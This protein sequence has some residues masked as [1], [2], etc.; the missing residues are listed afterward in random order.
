MS[1]KKP[2]KMV[3]GSTTASDFISS[4]GYR[5][6]ISRSM[7]NLIGDDD[8]DS[9]SSKEEGYQ[10][11]DSRDL[12]DMDEEEGISNEHKARP[13]IARKRVKQ[14]VN[15][16]E[17]ET[18]IIPLSLGH[19]IDH[20]LDP[21]IDD[22]P[23]APLQRM[24][25]FPETLF[26]ILCN[27]SLSDIIT[28]RPHGRS[29]TILDRSV[30][31]RSVLPTYY[32]TS[33]MGSF[34]KQL[35]GY[36]FNK[37]KLDVN[38]YTYYHPFFLRG[39]PHLVKNI[40]RNVSGTSPAKGGKEQ[41]TEADLERISAEAPV[42]DRVSETSRANAAIQRINHQYEINQLQEE[43]S[44][45]LLRAQA[46]VSA[47]FPSPQHTTLSNIFAGG[48][49][50]SPQV[51]Y[52]PMLPMSAT[53]QFQNVAPIVNSSY[54]HPGAYNHPQV[55]SGLPAPEIPPP[56]GWDT[57]TNALLQAFQTAQAQRQLQD[58]AQQAQLTLLA[59]ALAADLQNTHSHLS[60]P[61]L[62]PSQLGALH[63]AV[64]NLNYAHVPSTIYAP[65]WV[66]GTVQQ[67]QQ[68]RLVAQMLQQQQNSNLND[69]TNFSPSAEPNDVYDNE[70]NNAE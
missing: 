22:P 66:P 69:G 30:F 48:P 26:A 14:R 15:P 65:R 42:P 13:A 35:N 5:Q 16:S 36:S 60:Y 31:A 51:N 70:Q 41:I 28:W 1:E 29:F 58:Q 32:R 43:P 57:V 68:Q 24:A 25:N 40:K 45:P 7:S 23:F 54:Y 21:L 47:S 63:S 64:A 56:A 18:Q 37:I 33:R 20:S 62:T 38:Q 34:S 50:F 17:E 10:R 67:Q 19:Y 9:I 2:A 12:E 8:N 44:E 6:D 4:G 39:L 27:E 59:N 3:G 55:G 49:T 52:E 46:P 11:D 53:S 61:T